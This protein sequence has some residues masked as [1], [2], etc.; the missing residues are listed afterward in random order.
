MTRANRRLANGVT[1][2]VMLIL[3]VGLIGMS[4][5]APVGWTSQRTI[6]GSGL[7]WTPVMTGGFGNPGNKL[8][9]GLQVFQG[10]LY[11]ITFNDEGGEVYRSVTLDPLT[12]EKVVDAGF[13][14]LGNAFAPKFR[15]LSVWAGQ[16]FVGTGFRRSDGA[17]IW[18]SSDGTVWT[19]SF[20]SGELGNGPTL[21]V[22]AMVSFGDYLYAGMGAEFVGTAQIF[23]SRTGREWEPVVD[24]G[25]GPQRGNDNIYSLGVFDGRLY[26]GTFN[27]RGAE[28][29]RSDDG[30][31][32]ERVATRGIG[33]RR[34]LYIYELR[35]YQPTPESTPRLI[36]I[37]GPNPS[38]GQVWAYDGE[39]WSLFA[40]PGF[41]NQ[42]NTD[43]WQAN[44]FGRDFY[45]GTFK[46][47]IRPGSRLSDEDGAELWR[48]DD[49][50]GQWV[51]ETLD[52]FGNPNNTGI[53]TIFAW[54]GALYVGTLNEETG[55]ELWRGVPAR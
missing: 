50:T 17:Q 41:G 42:R 12:W 48:Y 27:L 33:D 13:L 21:N 46:E 54:N 6:R 18:R 45:V 55:C 44:Q 36:A 19:L 14:T 4:P 11:A 52:G 39:A 53:R 29:Y 5:G 43:M 26:A 2:V 30:R 31:T 8:L 3:G 15:S 20:D 1:G 23:R 10:R 24:D 37:T 25:F 32:W 9:R 35:V 47:E 38:G 16:L 34:N 49:A 7:V 51:P 22:R 40:P 28:I